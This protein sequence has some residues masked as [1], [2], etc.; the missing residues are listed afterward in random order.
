MKRRRFIQDFGWL[1]AGLGLIPACTTTPADTKPSKIS[2]VENY[3]GEWKTQD[4]LP[5]FD[6]LIDQDADLNSLW[7]PI[8]R[9]ENRRHFH[10]IGNRAL[11]VVASNRGDI[12]IFEEREGHRWLFY[13]DDLYGCGHSLILESGGVR[14]GSLYSDRPRDTVPLRQFGPTHFSVHSEY[15]GLRLERTILCPEGDRSWVLVKVQLTLSLDAEPRQ[16]T[17]IE[18]WPL[19]PR[20]LNTF[21]SDELRDKAALRVS[22][23]I[24]RSVQK[25]VAQEIFNEP[26]ETIG[27][28]ATLL[29]EDLSPENSG[30]M[31][32]LENDQWPTLQI[33]TGLDLKPG[34]TQTLWFRVGRSTDEEISSPESFYEQQL[35]KVRSRVPKT[36]SLSVPHVAREIP[37]HVAM[38]SGGANKDAILGGHTLNQSSVYGF[39][40]G[41]NAA[42]RDSLQH[43]IPLVYSEPDLAL[44]VL[45]NT[46]TWGSPDG[47]L[48]YALTGNKKPLTQLLRPSDQNL[49][50]LWLASEYAAVTGDLAAFEL[51]QQYH[52]DYSAASTTLKDNLKKQ[53]YFF[54]DYVGRGQNGHVRILNSDWNDMVLQDPMIDKNSMIEKGSSVLNSAMGSWVLDRF[55]PLM[56]NLGERNTADLCRSTA[57]Q[58]RELVAA[59]WNGRWF[60]RGYGPP[61][62]SQP[63]GTVIG[64]DRCWLEVQPWAILCG[65]ASSEQSKSLVEIFKTGHCMH[66]PLGARVIWPPDL[67][68]SRVGE[69]TL[70]GIWYSINMTLIWATAKI[71]PEFAL[72]Q[73]EAMSLQRHGEAYPSVWEGTLSGPDAWNAPESPRA[74]R[75]WSTPAFSMQSFPVSNMHSHSQPVLAW[76]RL[77]G[78]EP[79]KEGTLAVRSSYEKALGSYVSSTFSA[80]F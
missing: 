15:E 22:Y 60:D 67:S 47:D 75:T 48:P 32:A 20:F 13:Q 74:G 10:V 63:E 51:P 72:A 64:R 73:W 65:A 53:A 8:D 55:A 7:D 70:G 36:T 29:L 69:G 16:L 78:I 19:R 58:L 6:Y 44:S 41:G 52:P 31:S 14:W 39:G 43:A 57:H 38:L 21:Q 62:E 11:Q 79:T 80:S 24:N 66:S 68:N 59:S 42:A 76:L 17:H 71:D 40:L 56:E 27:A 77:L 61:T 50:A 4:G 49:W 2:K 12:G 18:S 9:P 37:W 46:C 30:Q 34:D 33:E 45:R 5:V 25:I 35:N 1:G 23:D 54:I 3:F 26:A 28:P